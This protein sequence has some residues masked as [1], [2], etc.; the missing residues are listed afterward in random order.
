M[1]AM[2]KRLLAAVL[3][4][5]MLLPMVASAEAGPRHGWRDHDRHDHHRPHHRKHK[6]N[7]AGAAVAA[8]IIGLVAG[9]ILLGAT[10]RPSYAGPPPGPAYYPPAPYPPVPY[11]PEPY[12]PAPYPG[13]VSGHPGFQPWSPAWYDYCAS[14]YRSF[15][16]R[17]GTYTTYRGEQKFC[18]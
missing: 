9:A 12:Q 1:N 18:Q 3:S 6:N 8:G 7:N 15:N 4:G 13:Y 2:S 5:A 16:A 17:T 10:S 14:K 11:E